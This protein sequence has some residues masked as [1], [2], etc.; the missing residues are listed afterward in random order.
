MSIYEPTGQARDAI[1]RAALWIGVAVAATAGTSQAQSIEEALESIARE[2]RDGQSPSRE[3]AP[4]PATTRLEQALLDA[5]ERFAA[6]LSIGELS[7]GMP[8]RLGGGKVSGRLLRLVEHRAKALGG[9]DAQ[10]KSLGVPFHE[11]LADVRLVAETEQDVAALARQVERRG[12]TVTATFENTVLASLPV[13]DI[14]E[15]DQ[16]RDCP[17]CPEMVVVPAGSYQMGLPSR[18]PGR[19]GYEGPVHRVTIAAPFA[20]GKYEVTFAEWDA[21]EEAGGCG[22]YSP[23]D[24]G[25]GRGQRPVINVS[26]DDAQRYVRWLSTKTKKPYRLLT[27]SEWEYAARAGTQTAYSWGDQIGSGRANC[28]G[29]GSQ[30]DDRQTAPVGSFRANA[31]GLYD[32]HGNVWEWVEDCWNDSYVGA[33]RDGSVWRSGNCSGRVMRGG[34]WFDIPSGLRAAFRVWDATG[35]RDN[36]N[37]FRVARTLAPYDS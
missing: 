17:Q 34:S 15:G 10:A 26:W 36:D 35:V 37:G 28:D 2:A 29:C 5:G 32:M 8:K 11:G 1:R 9:L 14:E 22:G 25:W 24:N 31:W 7:A 6:D 18:E 21:C 27:E 23:Q 19:A 4:D 13:G 20:V 12:G 16:F 3:D 33:P 30:W